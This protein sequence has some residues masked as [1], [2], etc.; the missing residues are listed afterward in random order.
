MVAE[1][2]AH[3][4]TP[5]AIVV[6]LWLLFEAVC[7]VVSAQAIQSLYDSMPRRI[8]TVITTRGSVIALGVH[9][10]GSMLPN[11]LKI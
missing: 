8:T 3:H 5:V 2:L 11:L 10:P 4:H 7:T 1:R 9:A 6:E